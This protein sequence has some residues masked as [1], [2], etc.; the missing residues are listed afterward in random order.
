MKLD[1]KV[2]SYDEIIKDLIKDNDKVESKMKTLVKND[3]FAK[4]FADLSD[5]LE[6]VKSIV[7]DLNKTK[8]QKKK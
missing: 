8:P 3:D 4:K 1:N 5:E 6:S 7:Y 2:E